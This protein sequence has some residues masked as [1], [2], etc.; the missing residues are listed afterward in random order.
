MATTENLLNLRIHKLSQKQYND[1]AAAGQLEDTSLYLTPFELISSGA[2]L[3]ADANGNYSWPSD[4]NS[5]IYFV[6][7]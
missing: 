7:E 1:A 3:T 6:L 4:N 5:M 2:D